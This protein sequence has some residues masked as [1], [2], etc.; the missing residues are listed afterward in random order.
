MPVLAPAAVPAAAPADLPGVGQPEAAYIPDA[1]GQVESAAQAPS[2]AQGIFEGSSFRAGTA[3]R[4]GAVAAVPPDPVHRLTAVLKRA[5]YWVAP[6]V[7]MPAVD[8]KEYMYHGTS[9]DVLKDIVAGGGAMKATVSY[10]ADEY[11]F[12]RG[13][14]RT[15]SRKTASPGFVLQF[16]T[17][18]IADKLV[19][20]HYQ[21]VVYTGRGKPQVSSHFMMAVQDIPLSV[22]TAASKANILDWMAGQRD[23]HP[24]DASWLPLIANFER[25]LG[26]KAPLAVG[27]GLRLDG[28][29]LKGGTWRLGGIKLE[30]LGQGESGFVDAHPLMPGAVI[31]TVALSPEHILAD[32]KAQ[33]TADAEEAVARTLAAAGVG[34]RYIG[35]SVHAGV[36]VSVRERIYGETVAAMI[37]G[38]RFREE[39]RA[40]VWDMLRRLAEAGIK[41]SDMRPPNIMIGHTESDAGRKAYIVDGGRLDV[42]PAGSAVDQRF[43]A[44]LDQEAILSTRFD[45]HV[46]QIVRSRPFDQ[47]LREGVA[48]SERKGLLE[49]IQDAVRAIS[50]S[51][52]S[53]PTK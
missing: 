24:E 3:D 43:E 26:A 27:T 15:S 10:F 5:A 19:T 8:G 52:Y 17:P 18:A 34:P 51:P 22:M 6:T 23:A 36:L 20:G 50:F 47:I 46:G 1:Q 25:A 29:Q 11:G 16:E 49:R 35:R 4:A 28:L 21:P 53:A 12:P 48:R 44:L 40:L 42:F 7:R 45:P 38:R 37:T 30:R 14:A 31:K 13:Y 41:V 32:E 2:A 9:F 33:E 39:D